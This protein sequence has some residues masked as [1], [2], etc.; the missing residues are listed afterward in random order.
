MAFKYD[1]LIL[2]QSQRLQAERAEAVSE[3]EAGR[4]TEDIAR[5]REAGDRILRID[6][7]HR[8][9]E[10]IASQFVMRQQ[11]VPFYGDDVSPRD[12][13]LAAKYGLTAAEIGIARNWTSDERVSP[14]DKF[15]EYAQQR[16]KYQ[17]MR[18]T[19]A[20]RDDQGTIRR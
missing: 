17:H 11:A 15:R 12:A 13:Q 1:D 18:A 20:Y 6:N 3:L 9:L 10:E 4:Q 7:E 16:A 14:E 19:G 2:D 8:R 5:C